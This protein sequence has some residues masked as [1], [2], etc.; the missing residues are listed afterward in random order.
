[1]VLEKPN[2]G[3]TVATTAK[4]HTATAWGNDGEKIG[5][6]HSLSVKVISPQFGTTN[7]YE[8]FPPGE[9][10]AAPYVVLTDITGD[11]T[12]RNTFVETCLTY[13]VSACVLLGKRDEMFG[14]SGITV[15]LRADNS[16]YSQRDELERRGVALVARELL[17]AVQHHGLVAIHG[18]AE[19][20]PDEELRA[21]A[22]A[23]LFLD[24]AAREHA[25]T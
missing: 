23:D 15:T 25:P 6:D 11:E 3:I 13:A 22:E 18:A 4:F 16:F 24:R 21:D 9:D 1:M 12:P 10:G 14:S 8:I 17:R 5:N 2:I 7:L 19:E 20:P